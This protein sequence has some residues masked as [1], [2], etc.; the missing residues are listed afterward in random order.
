MNEEMKT[1]TCCVPQIRQQFDAEMLK[2]PVG[3]APPGYYRCLYE[4]RIKQRYK[5]GG[6]KHKDFEMLMER[7]EVLYGWKIAETAYKQTK[8]KALAQRPAKPVEAI[9]C[10]RGELGRVVRRAFRMLHDDT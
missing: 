6:R 8:E 1:T 5:M 4:D 7:Y 10:F 3:M 2:S 9:N